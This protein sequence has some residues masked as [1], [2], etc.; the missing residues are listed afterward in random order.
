MEGEKIDKPLH[1]FTISKEIA[2]SGLKIKIGAIPF[3]GPIINELLFDLTGRIKQNRINDFV[4]ELGS[5]M[6]LMES[7][8]LDFEFLKTEEFYDLTVKIFEAATKINSMEKGKAL[9]NIYLAATRGAESSDTDLYFIF[10]DFISS[11]NSNHIQILRFIKYC[12][13]DLKE[14]GTY[15]RYFEK[16]NIIY[17]NNALDKYEFKYYNGDLEAKALISTGSGLENWSQ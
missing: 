7:E 13:T 9:A 17:T 12:E 4:E 16:Y 8:M 10:L 2:I 6:K 5:K 11:I 14:I 3:L 15:E 1:H